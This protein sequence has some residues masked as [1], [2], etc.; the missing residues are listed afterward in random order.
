MGERNMDILNLLEATRNESV[1]LVLMSIAVFRVYLEII[2]FDFASLPMG[3][4]VAKSHGKD[5]V[6]RFH[7]MGLIFSIGYI[8]FFGPPLLLA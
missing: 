2:N 7:R 1:V 8:L 3:K 5:F 4:M 6:D